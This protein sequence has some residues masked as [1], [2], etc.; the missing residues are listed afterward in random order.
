MNRAVIMLLLYLSMV[1]AVSAQVRDMGMVVEGFH[2]RVP[3]PTPNR[4][5]N[6]RKLV[7]KC[8]I[9]LDSRALRRWPKSRR[10][11]AAAGQNAT[12]QMF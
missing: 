5:A 2:G 8:N 9:T 3:S 7:R 6:A 12:E 11:V 1:L 4:V 10:F